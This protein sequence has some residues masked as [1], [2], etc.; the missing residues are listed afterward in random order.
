MLGILK[1][2]KWPDKVRN[3]ELFGKHVTVQAFK[4]NVKNELVGA[5]G[6]PFATLSFVI[7]CGAEDDSC[8]DETELCT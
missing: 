6:L 3:L 5:N 7:S 4:D 2:I 8:G 1:K